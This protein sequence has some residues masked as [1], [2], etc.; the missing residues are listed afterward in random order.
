MV[1]ETARVGKAWAD[2]TAVKI[3]L[4]ILPM[5]HMAGL[6]RLI[7][8]GITSGQTAIIIEK[9]T[10]Q[11]MCEAIQRFKVTDLP[12]APPVLLHLLNSPVVDQYDLSSVKALNVGSA[13][14]SPDTVRRIM[15]KF[16]APC[17]QVNT[18]GEGGCQ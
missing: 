17:T 9:Y 7:Q 2:P 6:N 12:T 10:P 4:G 16:N 14:S 11:A 5:Y 15:Q 18:S 3:S 8:S 1:V 13:P